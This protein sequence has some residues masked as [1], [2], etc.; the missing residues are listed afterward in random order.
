MNMAANASVLFEIF[1]AWA[2]C[3][4]EGHDLLRMKAAANVHLRRTTDQPYLNPGI[5]PS[6]SLLNPQ[7]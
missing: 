2:I 3:I 4:R 1:A 5:G 6:V 7:K